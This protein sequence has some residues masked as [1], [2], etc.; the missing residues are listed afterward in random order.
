[1]KKLNLIAVT[2]I[3]AVALGAATAQ[4]NLITNG[5]FEEGNYSQSYPPYD[6]MRLSAAPDP[7]A[8]AITGWTVTQGSVDWINTYWKAADGSKSIDLSGAEGDAG[9]LAATSFATTKGSQYKI[10][11]ALSGNFDNGNG[12]VAVIVSAGSQSETYTFDYFSDWTHDNMGWQTK[13]FSFTAE[14]DT[15]TLK[16]SSGTSSGYGPVID[17]V[18]VVPI[19]PSAL[20]LGT[21]L[22]GLVG[23]GWRRRKV[24]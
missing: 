19:P 13:T 23:L 14:D 24:S 9:V 21:G 4:A 10:T 12:P 1:M 2:G 17:N 3:L 8:T 15:T 20:L 11:F 5:S 16:F 6:F 22:L 7:S 18:N